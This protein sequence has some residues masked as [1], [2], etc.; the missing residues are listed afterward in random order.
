[1]VAAAGIVGRLAAESTRSSTSCVLS[2]LVTACGYE[3]A[4]E[5]D[6]LRSDPALKLF[7]AIARRVYATIMSVE[8]CLITS[9][10]FGKTQPRPP[11]RL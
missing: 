9:M 3:D 5:L 11:Q 1:V 6:H 4:D 8:R 2:I 10:I 7:I